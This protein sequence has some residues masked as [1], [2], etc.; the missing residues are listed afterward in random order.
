LLSEGLV[1]LSRLYS[2]TELF[3]LK[4]LD[5][6]L[7]KDLLLERVLFAVLGLFCLI[8]TELLLLLV[9][10]RWGDDD[11]DERKECFWEDNDV[12]FLLLL[13]ILLSKLI[14]RKRMRY[15]IGSFNMRIGWFVL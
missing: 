5:S 8:D 13:V 7:E 2:N 1:D 11:E 3:F 6:G 14:I 10:E 15:F 12:W 9:N 4:R